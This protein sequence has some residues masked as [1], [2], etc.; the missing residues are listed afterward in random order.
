MTTDK[1]LKRCIIIF[2]L[3]LFTVLTVSAVPVRGI[4]VK[5]IKLEIKQEKI[6][7]LEFMADEIAVLSLLGESRF[8]EAIQV[9]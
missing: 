4:V 7:S 8:L 9:E 5:N 6:L 3:S 1:W 2:L